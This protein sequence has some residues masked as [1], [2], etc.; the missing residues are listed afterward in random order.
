MAIKVT[1]L[2]QAFPGL[3][4][5]TNAHRC[6]V[7]ANI[8]VEYLRAC[9]ALIDSREKFGFNLHVELPLMHQALELLLKAHAARVDDQFS[10]KTYRHETTR[11]L[12]DYATRVPVFQNLLANQATLQLFAGLESAWLAY[13]YGE[14]IAEFTGSSY[15]DAGNIANLLADEYFKETGT[16][17][18]AHH[19]AIIQ[20]RKATG[21]A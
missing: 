9:A 16:P 14:S 2:A 18:Q 20:A 4:L 17:L 19:F 3:S 13:R 15:N 5:S 1:S 12:R 11:L 6:H 21:A 8:G 10:P 7:M